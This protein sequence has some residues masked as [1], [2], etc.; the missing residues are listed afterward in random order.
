MLAASLDARSRGRTFRR[1]IS[2]ELL[3]DA[4]F[5]REDPA[6]EHGEFA[7]RGGIVDVFPAGDPHP[8]RLEFIG[9][10]IETL[11]TYDPATQ[12]SIAPID[13][14]SIIPLRDV[15]DGDR[16]ATIFDYLAAASAS[17]IIISERDEVEAHATKVLQQISQSY[18]DILAN[19]VRGGAVSAPTP[20]ELLVDWDTVAARFAPATTLSILGD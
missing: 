13:Q 3:V 1:S 5:S 8:V 10:T 11:R 2:A 9:D 15:L 14:V 17:R 18:Q 7:I 12:R 16:G 6:D 4:G 19:L 20:D